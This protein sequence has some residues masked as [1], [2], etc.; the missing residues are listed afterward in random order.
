MNK[1]KIENLLI[2]TLWIML[3]ILCVCFWF[4]VMY[5]FNIFSNSH[6]QHL[7]YMQAS[8][9]PVKTS[10][11]ISLVVSVII[12]LGGLFMIIRPRIRKINFAQQKQKTYTHTQSGQQNNVNTSTQNT[13][14]N[15]IRPRRL[16]LNK[17]TVTATTDLDI[18]SKN[19]HQ[20]DAPVTP[21]SAPDFD[22]LQL[23]PSTP[24]PSTDIKETLTQIFQDAGYITK[25]TPNIHGTNI[26]LLAL[27]ANETI[28]IGATG[29]STEIMDATTD[30]IKQIFTDTLDD[31]TINIKPF[32]ISPTNVTP[33]SET[34]IFDSV[35]D[36]RT[37]MARNH[38][39]ELSSE[40]DQETFDAFSSYMDTVIN[41]LGTL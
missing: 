36:V 11:Y 31:I 37:Y 35:D 25:D 32:I 19:I 39:P 1:N 17:P 2:I 41:Y 18:L 5:G 34:I 13:E 30:V 27:G 7:S 10:F 3:S 40:S 38:N 29:I 20:T 16:N 28:W 33:G 15:M 21:V 26:T 8:Q 14:S 24:T 22:T 23:Y 6:W 9:T 12:V 4:N